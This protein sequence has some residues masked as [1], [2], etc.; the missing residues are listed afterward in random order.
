MKNLYLAPMEGITK[1]VYRNAFAHHYGGADK[2]FTPFLSHVKLNS[3]DK[4]DVLPQNNEGLDVVPQILANKADVFLTISHYLADYGYKEVNLNLGCPSG[5]V[6]A[7]RRGAGFLYLPEELDSFLYEIFEKCPLDISVK[8]RIGV[9]SADEWDGIIQIYKK[10]P[11]KELIIHPRL[12]CQFYNGIPDNTA[13]EKACNTLD[14][15]LCYNGNISSAEEYRAV[16]KAFPDICSVMI[17]RGAI[18]N[19]EIFNIIRGKEDKFD[20]QTFAAFH[21][22]LMSEYA[23]LM[24]GDRPALFHLKELWSYMRT[25][26]GIDDKQFKAILKTTRLNE[27][28]GLV[29]TILASL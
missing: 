7:K 24:S 15:P 21:Y 5:T 28:E 1:F 11:I 19:P 6:V 13:F 20:K 16:V 17:G 9:K 12:Q 27:Y 22:E 23:G 14:V 8:T 25:T 26:V 2:Y 18:A 3:K 4:N 29:N 10:Y